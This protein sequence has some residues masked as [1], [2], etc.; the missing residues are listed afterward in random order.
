MKAADC[1][2]SVSVKAQKSLNIAARSLLY[3]QEMKKG[4]GV[5]L[6]AVMAYALL[7]VLHIGRVLPV[8]PS[9]RARLPAEADFRAND[10][11]WTHVNDFW[12]GVS[13]LYTMTSSAITKTSL[14]GGPILLL[15]LDPLETETPLATVEDKNPEFLSWR[16]SPLNSWRTFRSVSPGGTREYTD[17]L[18]EIHPSFVVLERSLGQE[19]WNVKIF[20]TTTRVLPLEQ[21]RLEGDSTLRIGSREISCYCELRGPAGSW[22]KTW[23]SL[24]VPGGWVMTQRQVPGIGVRVEESV[25][26]YA[27]GD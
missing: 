21:A 19:R 18:R 10:R 24:Q 5:G 13:G 12:C 3:F 27:S 8:D 22:E 16:A 1:L 20:S 7:H 4:L 17:R 23:H 14:E 11:D 6:L 9:P 2:R 15:P 25:V 26:D